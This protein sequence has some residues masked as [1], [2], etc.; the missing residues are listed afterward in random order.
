MAIERVKMIKTVVAGEDCWEAGE[1]FPKPGKPLHPVLLD[2]LRNRTGT[3][4]VLSYT[5]DVVLQESNLQMPLSDN[6]LAMAQSKEKEAL[7]EAKL[8]KA[9]ADALLIEKRE[10][11]KTIEDLQMQFEV[12]QTMVNGFQKDLQELKERL[13]IGQEPFDLLS[14]RIDVLEGNLV[15]QKE[16]APSM[17][18]SEKKAPVK[19]KIIVRR[20]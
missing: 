5:K 16:D 1:I 3:V 20:K 17:K 15:V 6:V 13:E 7:E 8:E 9:R 19:R 2:E 14:E 11:A 4:E 18:T 12:L 10:L